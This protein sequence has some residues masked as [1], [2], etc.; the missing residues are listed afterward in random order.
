[1]AAANVNSTPTVFING[2]EL[3]PTGVAE[4]VSKIEAAVDQAS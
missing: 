4:M 1:M 2:E 3:P